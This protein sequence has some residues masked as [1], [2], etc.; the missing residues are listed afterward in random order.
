M[1]AV[2][3]VILVILGAFGLVALY[4]IYDT[5]RELRKGKSSSSGEGRAR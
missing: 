4:G 2:A 5:T 3:F 1:T